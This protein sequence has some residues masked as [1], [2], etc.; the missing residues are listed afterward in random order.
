VPHGTHL[1]NSTN[2]SGILIASDNISSGGIVIGDY[3]PR[4][5]AYILFSVALPFADTL[6][7]GWTDYRAVGVVHPR[8]ANEY[9]NTTESDVFRPC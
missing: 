9:Y 2:P 1:Y 4:A 8:G 5:G 3:A 6:Q 7:C